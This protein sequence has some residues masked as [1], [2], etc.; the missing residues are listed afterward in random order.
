MNC[1][2]CYQMWYLARYQNGALLSLN[3]LAKSHAWCPGLSFHTWAE[4]GAL[5]CLS[6]PLHCGRKF[7]CRQLV[8]SPMPA[9]Q[10]VLSSKGWKKSSVLCQAVFFQLPSVPSLLLLQPAS[11]RHITPGGGSC[12]PWQAVVAAE[13]QFNSMVKDETTAGSPPMYS[14]WGCFPQL[15]GEPEAEVRRD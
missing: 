1:I 6:Q 8:G 2:L 10:I 5:T 3:S 13:R 7:P 15:S 12:G 14:G 4:A 11:H 9:A